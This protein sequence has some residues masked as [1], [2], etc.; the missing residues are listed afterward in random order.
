MEEEVKKDIFFS[1][2]AQEQDCS[3]IIGHQHDHDASKDW[4]VTRR[5]LET[6]YYNDMKDGELQI[7]FPK[8]GIFTDLVRV[9][10]VIYSEFYKNRH[11]NE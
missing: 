8:T 1:N 6:W 2:S 7:L 10:T 5:K 3:F 4:R 9:L 11:E